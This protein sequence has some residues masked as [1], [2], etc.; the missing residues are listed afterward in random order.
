MMERRHAE[1]R[2]LCPK[3]RAESVAARRTIDYNQLI[4]N[5]R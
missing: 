2:T 3:G 1:L 5:V 4:L